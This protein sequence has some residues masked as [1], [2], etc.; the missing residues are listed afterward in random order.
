MFY[1]TCVP[2][3]L[4]ILKMQFF[5][6]KTAD[7]IHQLKQLINKRLDLSND[8]GFLNITCSLLFEYESELIINIV[9]LEFVY[10]KVLLTQHFF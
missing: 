8:N 7:G 9:V 5:F 6:S 2:N 10:L 4:F 3:P 1:L